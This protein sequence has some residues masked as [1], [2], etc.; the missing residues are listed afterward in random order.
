M[1][2][3]RSGEH[4]HLCSVLAEAR[5]DAGLT[6]RELASRLRRPHSFVAKVE[7]GERRLDVIEFVELARALGTDPK[8]LFAKVLIGARM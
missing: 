8:K 2:T 5:E 3:L 7:S 6:Q 1:K 4:R